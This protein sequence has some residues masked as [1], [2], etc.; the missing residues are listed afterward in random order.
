MGKILDPVLGKERTDRL[1][2]S[3]GECQLVVSGVSPGQQ[4]ALFGSG[5]PQSREAWGRW[6]CGPA[7]TSLGLGNGDAALRGWG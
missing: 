7:A 5:E 6:L 4:L 3:A 1:G 2:T